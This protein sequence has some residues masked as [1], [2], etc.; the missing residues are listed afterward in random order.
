MST[1]AFIRKR[2]QHEVT[3]R[4]K[5]QTTEGTLPSMPASMCRLDGR[6]YQIDACQP[7]ATVAMTEVPTVMKNIDKLA[8]FAALMMYACQVKTEAGAS[9]V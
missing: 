2:L 8:G 6:V 1:A 4:R 3:N 7:P 9:C 5:V